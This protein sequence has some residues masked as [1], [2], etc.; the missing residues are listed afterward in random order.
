MP[1]TRGVFNLFNIHVNLAIGSGR[2]T[3]R[4]LT[5]FDQRLFM[6]PVEYTLAKDDERLLGGYGTNINIAF[7]GGGQKILYR[8][9]LA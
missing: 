7:E 9:W 6:K 5:E 1:P 2:N 4:L 8:G 3:I